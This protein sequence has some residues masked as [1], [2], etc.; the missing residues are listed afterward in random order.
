[1]VLIL[2]YSTITINIIHRNDNNNDIMIHSINTN[3]IN[4]GHSNA[5]DHNWDVCP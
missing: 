5:N 2:Q 1:M 4:I 3:N